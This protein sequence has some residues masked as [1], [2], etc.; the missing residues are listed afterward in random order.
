MAAKRKDARPPLPEESPQNSD[1][2][3]DKPAISDKQKTPCKREVFYQP[4]AA[5]DLE[6]IVIYVG[7]VLGSPQAAKDLYE[8]ITDAASE[9]CELPDLGRAFYDNSLERKQ[10]RFLLVQNYRVFYTYDKK[11][12]TIWR[13]LHMRQDIDDY[14]L[15]GWDA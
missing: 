14:A 4:R 13:V 8:T 12:V 6:S 15:I 5:L 11:S 3:E 2:G 1:R 9:L 10:Y 7:E